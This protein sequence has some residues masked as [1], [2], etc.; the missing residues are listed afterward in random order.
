M[1]VTWPTRVFMSVFRKRLSL[2]SDTFICCLIISADVNGRLVVPRLGKGE[3]GPLGLFGLPLLIYPLGENGFDPHELL[4][5]VEGVRF[6]IFNPK[7][8]FVRLVTIPTP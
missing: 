1:E 8:L 3:D 7:A 2:L 4:L 6:N 5:R